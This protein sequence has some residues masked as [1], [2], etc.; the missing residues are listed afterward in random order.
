MQL[1][2]KH[3]EEEYSVVGITEDLNNTMIL[4]EHYIPGKS[5]KISQFYDSF[6]NNIIT[7]GMAS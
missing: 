1:A 7:T 2:K 6:Q 5:I 4:L 3:I